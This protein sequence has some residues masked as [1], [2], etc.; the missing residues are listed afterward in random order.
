MS[1]IESSNIFNIAIDILGF[2][3]RNMLVHKA[4]SKLQVPKGKH[5]IAYGIADFLVR[6]G[7]NLQLGKLIEE[8][9]DPK[10]KQ[11][12]LV[13]I[14]GAIGGM[15]VD[16]GE[17]LENLYRGAVGLGANYILDAALPSTL[18]NPKYM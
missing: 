17:P 9:N 6:K 12:I 13:A 16:G 7:W 10:M 1:L 8:N 3:G 18:L 2:W 15:I 14:L 4:T 11:D 5:V